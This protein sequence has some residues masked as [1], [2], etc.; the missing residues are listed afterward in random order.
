MEKL[1]ELLINEEIDSALKRWRIKLSTE[2]GNLEIEINHISNLY[3]NI[4][5]LYNSPGLS[6]KHR[7]LENLS[8]VNFLYMTGAMIQ[9]TV[10]SDNL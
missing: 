5:D 6:D 1:K 2:K 10:L 4:F 3:K 8:G 9:Q 7:L